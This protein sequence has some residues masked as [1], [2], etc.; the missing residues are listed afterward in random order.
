MDALAKIALSGLLALVLMTSA[1]C[2]STQPV[3]V[4][5]STSITPTGHA[6]REGEVG[7]DAA[8]RAAIFCRTESGQFFALSTEGH[9]LYG[10]QG[11]REHT[12]RYLAGANPLSASYAPV[13][14]IGNLWALSDEVT[15]KLDYGQ[16]GLAAM[17]RAVGRSG[18]DKRKHFEVC[19]ASI[20]LSG[21]GDDVFEDLLLAPVTTLALGIEKELN[22]RNVPPAR[23]EAL[24][25]TLE[26]TRGEMRTVLQEIARLRLDRGDLV[27]DI[28][29]YS[30]GNAVKGTRWLQFDMPGP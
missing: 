21:E 2:Q 25:A 20:Q 24:H 4:L 12:V 3:P 28:A 29:G 23:R 17:V 19:Y 30:Y 18:P 14:T 15:N 13:S 5:T 6:W 16:F 1:A 8:G 7:M 9:P 26:R 10:S 11:D 27:A 22:D